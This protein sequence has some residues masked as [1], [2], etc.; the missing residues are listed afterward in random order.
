MSLYQP[1]KQDRAS[2]NSGARKIKLHYLKKYNTI[3]DGVCEI[4]GKPIYKY[5]NGKMLTLGG[6]E[7]KHK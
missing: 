2:L 4:C 5:K 7:H 6:S 3:E 1:T